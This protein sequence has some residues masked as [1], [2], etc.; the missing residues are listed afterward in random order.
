MTFDHRAVD[1]GYAARFLAFLK[2]AVELR[3]WSTEL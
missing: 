2:E 3:D 1:G